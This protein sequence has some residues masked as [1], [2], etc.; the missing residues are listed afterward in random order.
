MDKKI[1]CCVCNKL[2]KK[3]YRFIGHNK[4][5][6]ELY[7]HERC[8]LYNLTDEKLLEIKNRKS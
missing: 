7:R 3:K 4:F 1:Y 5:G 6:V 2:I 8:K